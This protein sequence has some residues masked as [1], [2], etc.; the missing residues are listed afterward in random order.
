M[1]PSLTLP[2][3]LKL[4]ILPLYQ[5]MLH[6]R[7]LAQTNSSWSHLDFGSWIFIYTESL[8]KKSNSNCNGGK[9]TLAC[10][11][12]PHEKAQSYP[13]YLHVNKATL[14]HISCYN[15]R[16]TSNTSIHAVI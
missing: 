3:I 5:P 4:H 11:A 2:F 15:L 10:R 13:I 7:L 16:I 8:L 9:Y 12:P 14:Y 6:V 1:T